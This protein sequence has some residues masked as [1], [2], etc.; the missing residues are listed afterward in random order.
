M[1]CCCETTELASLVQ[2]KVS[3]NYIWQIYRSYSD[4]QMNNHFD[5]SRPF[6]KIILIIG[7]MI[8]GMLVTSILTA[9][10]LAMTSG[11]LQELMEQ[12]SAGE[13]KGSPAVIRG[14]LIIQH[15]SFFILPSMVFGWIIYKKDWARGF[16]LKIQ[17]T[18]LVV[19][20]GMMFLFASYPL[21][22]LS[23]LVNS[24]I[25]LPEWAGSLESQAAETMKAVLGLDSIA[26]LIMSLL[27]VAVMPAIGEELIF[28]GILQKYFGKTF[29]SDIAGIWVAA[30]LFSAIHFQFEGF[31]P[32]MVLGA[33]LGYLYHWSGTLWIPIL[34]HFLNNAVPLIVLYST[35]TDL[36]DMNVD[37][38]GTITWYLIL[39][40]IIV[41]YFLYQFITERS[42]RNHDVRVS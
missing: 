8:V 34:V 14:M 6:N 42:S 24:S 21:V 32:R 1:K 11:N 7:L 31:L 9:A 18:A 16:D 13:F 20:A 17:P 22:N 4:F 29:R 19:L 39:G 5:Q 36:S 26:G 33:I 10:M 12:L 27:I 15:I 37:D 40:S 38:S 23:Y 25:P 35:G 30:F 2:C 3:D 28:R 41:M